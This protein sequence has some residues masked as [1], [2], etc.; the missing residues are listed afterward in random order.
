MAQVLLGMPGPW[1]DDFR[2][3]SDHYTTKIGGLPVRNCCSSSHVFFQHTSVEFPN[4]FY[5][6]CNRTGLS[7]RNPSRLICL[8]A[9]HVEVDQVSLHR[10]FFGN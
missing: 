4:P 3:T 6:L 2:E 1:A 9:V 8:S 7:L 5:F 10:F